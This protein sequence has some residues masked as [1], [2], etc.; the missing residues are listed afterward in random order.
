VTLR[1]RLLLALAYVLLLAIIALG[2]PL[3]IN[4][5]AR[6]HAEVRTQAQAQAD[7]VAATA[8]DLLAPSQRDALQT[9]ARTSGGSIGGRILIVDGSGRVLA[10]SAGPAQLGSSYASRPEIQ[11]ALS[12][13]PVQVQRASQTLGQEILATAVPIL[14]NG[15]PAGAVRVT[16][17]IAAV[18]SAVRR[19]QLVVVLIGLI[20]LALGLAAGAVIAAQVGRPIGRL[21]QVARRVARGDLTARA[22]VEGS[23]EQ[24]SL[25]SS[26][27]EMTSRIE[28]LL[29]A[30]RNFVADASHQ[31]RT[32]LTGL[33]LRL[34]EARASLAPGE[35]ADPELDAA[36]VEVDRLARPVD[37]LLVLSRAG[38]HRLTG[39]ML[40]LDALAASARERWRATAAD[41]RIDLVTRR[42]AGEG[43]AWASLADAERA[44]DC[45]VENALQYSP[46]GSSVELVTAPGRIEVRDRGP[47]VAD[48][49]REAVFERFHRG[50]TGLAG[51][52]GSGLG[53]PIGRELARGWGGEVT[54]ENRQGGGA[55]A[56]LWL[57]P[58][59]PDDPPALPVFN[60]EPTSLTSR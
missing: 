53:L 30:Q 59:Q 15:R 7:L 19:A 54:L 18:H 5:S 45:L 35:G 16:Q 40:E 36:M 10:D 49:E 3:A 24:R 60:P 2:I 39:T 11:R 27:N 6:V 51:P 28:R 37:E 42:D 21:E 9:M 4:L 41:R 32:P 52:P 55:V 38:E 50:R 23:R 48:D 57:S 29:Q 34:E 17:S 47:G 14:R 25:A 13:H 1:T 33:R 58:S 8:A 12:G 22:Q 20:V 56:T 44:L 46:A 26:F 43:M 31:L